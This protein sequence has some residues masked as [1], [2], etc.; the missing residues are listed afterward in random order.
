[1]NTRSPSISELGL[2]ETPSRAMTLDEY[3]ALD[4]DKHY[5]RIRRTYRDI[6]RRTEGDHK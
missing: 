3:N 5:R 4:D 2:S 1:M 6:P